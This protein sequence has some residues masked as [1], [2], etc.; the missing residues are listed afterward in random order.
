[1]KK[2]EEKRPPEGPNVRWEDNM[3]LDLQ[4]IEWGLDWTD[5]AQD[6][7]KWLA[8]VNTIKNLQFP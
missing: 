5:L 1:M 3:K 6:R 8:I 2:S 7:D 4:D